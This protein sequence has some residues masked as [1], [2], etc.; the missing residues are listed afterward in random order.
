MFFGLVAA[1]NDATKDVASSPTWSGASGS[2][3]KDLA[4]GS[5]AS[6]SHVTTTV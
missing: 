1:Y 6:T 2:P 5:A 3:Y 4:A